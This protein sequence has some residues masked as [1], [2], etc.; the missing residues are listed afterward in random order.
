MPSALTTFAAL[1]LFVSVGVLAQAPAAL[2]DSRAADAPMVTL[3]EQME[4][5]QLPGME[6]PAATRNANLDH[7]LMARL[8]AM[9]STRQ[10][11]ATAPAAASGFGA[12]LRST[13]IGNSAKSESRQG[14]EVEGAR[15]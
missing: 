6:S 14:A 1:A 11:P 9:N 10:V 12:W 2:A 15:P 3:E 5:V 8:A 7:R 13:F 4:L